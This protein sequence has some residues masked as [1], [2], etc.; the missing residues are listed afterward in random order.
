MRNRVPHLV[1]VDDDEDIRHLN[2]RALET[3]GLGRVV[4]VES[5][6]ALLACLEASLLQGD[7]VDLI[8][9]DIV[10]P[11]IDGIEGCRRVHAQQ[12]FRDIPIVMLTSL[13]DEDKLEE[14]FEAGA[15]DYILKPFSLVELR[16]RVR[17]AL[18]LKEEM[19]RRR[20]HEQ[21]LLELTR[22]LM[23]LQAQSQRATYLDALTGMYNRRAFDKKL[24]DEWRNCYSLRKP[25]SLIMLDID[26]F[27][28]YNDVYGHPA[29]DR[30]LQTVASA[31]PHP[32]SGVFTAR[33]GGEEFALILPELS[34]ERAQLLAEEVRLRV[35]NLKLSHL[36]SDVATVVTASLGVASCVPGELA[37]SVELIELADRALY[38]AKAQGRNRVVAS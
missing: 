15:I 27:K 32:E 31:L 12:A 16:S 7:P 36:E 4:G 18:R 3:L 37:D 22:S 17:S 10:M 26:F 28:R 35:E 29:G 34:L 11:E 21:E 1:L 38:I 2:L 9:M 30:C 14:A 6:T 19:D 23:E 24:H 33:Y 5:V 13:R 8:L 20:E 25:L